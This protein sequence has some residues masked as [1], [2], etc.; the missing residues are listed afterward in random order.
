M[1]LDEIRKEFGKTESNIFKIL[2]KKTTEKNEKKIAVR[3]LSIGF[4]NGEIFGLLGTNGAGKTTTINMICTELKPDAG[5]IKIKNQPFDFKNIQ[6]FCKN[7][8]VCP[9]HNPF[10]EELTLIDHLQIYGSIKK[11]SDDE[12]MSLSLK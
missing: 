2:Q 11:L 12:I 6:L 7:V 3:N 4:R 9:Q 10:W 8:A 5:T 1:V